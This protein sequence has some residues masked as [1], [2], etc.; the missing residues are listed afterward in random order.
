MV[1]SK[2]DDLKF[3]LV[4]KITKPH[5]LRGEVKIFPFSGDPASFVANYSLLQLARDERETKNFLSSSVERVRVQG[6]QVIIK[7]ESCSDRNMSE[8]LSGFFV[9]VRDCDLPELTDNEF[10][11]YEL[12]GKQIVDTK[13][14]LI[15]LIDSILEAGGQELLVVQ[16]Q[17]REVL[18]PSAPDFIVAMEEDRIIVDLPL[19]LL[20]IE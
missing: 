2:K 9:F 11:L 7:L 16:Y 5:G 20:D 18:I 8:Q 3:I 10:Y 15:G 12:I 4:G 1:Y 14:N 17:G 6:K 19:G 13:G